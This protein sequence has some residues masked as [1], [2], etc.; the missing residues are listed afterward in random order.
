M[1]LAVNQF[2]EYRPASQWAFDI[3]FSNPMVVSKKSNNG[4]T[5]Q[6]NK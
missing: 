2:Y 1:K 3:T 5:Y 4:V 6:L